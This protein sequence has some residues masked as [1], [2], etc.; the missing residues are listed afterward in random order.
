[1]CEHWS[2]KAVNSEISSYYCHS[3]LYYSSVI[4]K[5]M[6]SELDVSF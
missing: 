1:M 2:E 4:I 5:T 6:Y 3:D